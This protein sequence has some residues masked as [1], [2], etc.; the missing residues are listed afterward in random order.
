MGLNLRTV[1]AYLLNEDFQRL[2][3]SRSPT[4]ARRFLTR[5]CRSPMRSRLA[6]L[7]KV[8]KMLRKR[9]PLVFN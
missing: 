6:P 1:R 2:W 7:R 4:Q 5:W 8:A 9:R 3:G